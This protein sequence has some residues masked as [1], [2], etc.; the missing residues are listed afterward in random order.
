MLAHAY[1]TAYMV[2]VEIHELNIKENM[3]MQQLNSYVGM[4]LRNVILDHPTLF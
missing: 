3:A 4:L 1:I 2:K